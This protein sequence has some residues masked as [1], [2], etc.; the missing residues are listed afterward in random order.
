MKDVAKTILERVARSGVT[1]RE[2]S[3]LR[4][5]TGTRQTARQVA[6]NLANFHD[7]DLSIA[8]ERLAKGLSD[9]RLE[10]LGD[11]VPQATL[12]QFVQGEQPAQ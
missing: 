5:R 1:V 10:I 4:N 9:G 11:D 3:I 8:A 6:Q 12:T 7:G 2:A